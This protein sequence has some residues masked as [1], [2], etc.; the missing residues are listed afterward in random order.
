LHEFKEILNTFDPIS[1][2]E[3]DNVKL[4]NR[5]DTKFTFPLSQLGNLLETIKEDYSCLTINDSRQSVYKTL[6]YDTERLGLYQQ[7]HNGELNR[8]KIRHRT[9]IDS[10]LAYLEVKFKSNKDRTIKRRIKSALM[11]NGFQNEALY[12]LSKE[13]PFS[14]LDLKPIVWVNYSRITLVSKTSAERL[15]LDVNLE[16][17]RDERS[18]SLDNMVIA[19]VKQ[20]GKQNSVFIQAVKK[21]GI[22]EGAISKYCLAVMLTYPEIKKNNFKEKLRHINE[23]LHYDAVTNSHR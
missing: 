3:M 4:M 11:L 23:V 13:L 1:L 20:A 2:G 21:H 16:V 19:E 9:Y 7:H 12:F 18:T 22:R 15:T 8:Y 17:K 5:T 10:G 6:Y 14:P